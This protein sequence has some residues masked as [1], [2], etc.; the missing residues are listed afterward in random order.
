MRLSQRHGAIDRRRLAVTDSR[1]D[2]L[3]RI[4]STASDLRSREPRREGDS[5]DLDHASSCRRRRRSRARLTRRFPVPSGAFALVLSRRSSTSGATR[6]A[7][8]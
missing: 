7:R 6:N 5:H 1:P 4:A 2:A 3:S 8:G